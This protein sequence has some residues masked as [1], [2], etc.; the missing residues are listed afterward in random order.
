MGTVTKV[1]NE[2]LSF[3]SDSSDCIF[4]KG[5]LKMV[6]DMDLEF[7]SNLETVVGTKVNGNLV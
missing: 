6:Y 1:W 5:V 2:D 4:V 3:H 7:M